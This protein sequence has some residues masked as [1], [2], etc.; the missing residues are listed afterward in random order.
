[1]LNEGGDLRGLGDDHPA[2]AFK[3]V[4]GKLS[5]FNGPNGQALLMDG[6][7]VIP[8]GLCA[9]T[10]SSLHQFHPSGEAISLEA[11][12]KIYWPG[13]RNEVMNQYI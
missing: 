7:L 2:K 9:D 10:L 8:R 12:D 5:T 11:R 4:W 6:R 13:L 1:M 3:S